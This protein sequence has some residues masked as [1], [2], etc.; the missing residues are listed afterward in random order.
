LLIFKHAEQQFMAEGQHK[1]LCY[2][3][4]TIHG[5]NAIFL[6]LKPK[7]QRFRA[8]GHSPKALGSA[9]LAVP[10]VIVGVQIKDQL[11]HTSDVGTTADLLLSDVW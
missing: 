8:E 11:N 6:F 4:T 5:N 9:N 2:R 10:R 1:R 3:V 7:E